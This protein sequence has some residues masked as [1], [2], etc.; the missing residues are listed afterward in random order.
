[1]DDLREYDH[2]LGDGVY[3]KRMENGFWLATERYP[4]IHKI[5]MDEEM[6]DSLNNLMKKVEADD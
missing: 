3:F 1:M 4:H 5:F 6:L 2:Y